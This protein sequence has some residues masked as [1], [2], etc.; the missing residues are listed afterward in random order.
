MNS[1]NTAA[2]LFAG[3]VPIAGGAAAILITL[4]KDSP[5]TGIIWGIGVAYVGFLLYVLFIPRPG[6]QFSFAKNY[7]PGA[8]ARY[9]VMIGAFCVVVFVLKIHGLS[10]LAGIFAGMMTATIISLF[11]MRRTPSQPPEA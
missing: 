5:V 11:K 4:G 9:V 6:K 3:F 10:V 2:A 8:V 1:N 7:L